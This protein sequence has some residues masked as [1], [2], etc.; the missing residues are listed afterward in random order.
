VRPPAGGHRIDVTGL[1]KRFGEVTALDDLTFS[2]RPGVV[3]GFLGPNGAGKTTTLR[4]LLGLVAPTSGS[5]TV[6]GRPYRDLEN[7]LS[8]V[9]AALEASSFHPGRSARAHLQVMAL[10]AGLPRAR[11]DLLLGQVG[12]AEFADRRVGGYSLGMRQR[13]ALAQALLGD[14]PVLI[15]D[16]PANG[17]DPAGI[18]WLR[19][20]LRTL[21]GEGRT[22]L[23]SSHVLSE[24]QQTVDDIVVI[25]R[26]RLVRQGSLASLDAGPAAVLVRTPTPDLL[27]EALTEY[28]VREVDGRLRVEGSTP[29]E[30]GH[31]AY[32]RGVELHELSAEASDLENVFLTMTADSEGEVA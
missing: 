5:A 8:Q 11:V 1:T 10:A 3:T 23:V 7:P 6:D 2:V 30:V 32:T 14:P 13:L 12:L 17:L 26:G 15:L 31:L 22:V 9:G 4:C 20:F 25:A 24:V 19:H 16:E 18:A 21:A 28:A 29:A 27:R